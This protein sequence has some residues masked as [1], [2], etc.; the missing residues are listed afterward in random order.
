MVARTPSIKRCR[1]AGAPEP[2]G[3]AQKRER[4]H[5]E[6]QFCMCT[7]DRS[8]GMLGYCYSQSQR[9]APLGLAGGSGLA[10]SWL[11]H[12]ARATGCGTPAAPPPAKSKHISNTSC[13]ST[14]TRIS[15]PT[16]P[17]PPEC[18]VL[19]P[20]LGI[21]GRNRPTVS[22]ALVTPC[23]P[24]RRPRT[25]TTRAPVSSVLTAVHTVRC[26]LTR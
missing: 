9:V 11:R 16:A 13:R 21:R 17:R 19:R 23:H 18:H 24:T 2:G 1:H 14:S 25:L 4:A 10:P 8:V 3:G 5:V 7:L 12:A 22:H 15:G 26:T 6:S 20:R